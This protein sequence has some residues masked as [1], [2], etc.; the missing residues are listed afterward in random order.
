MIMNSRLLWFCLL[1]FPLACTKKDDSKNETIQ[2]TP[3]E[4]TAFID[5]S[6]EA[7]SSEPENNPSQEDSSNSQ[8]ESGSDNEVNQDNTGDDEQNSEDGSNN[9]AV[10]RKIKVITDKELVSAYELLEGETQMTA[11]CKDNAQKTNLVIQ[12]FCVEGFR[13]T[14]LAELQ[15]ALNLDPSKVTSRGNNGANGNPGFAITAHSSS[16]VGSFVSAINPRVIIFNSQA[17]GQSFLTKNF[18]AMGFVRGEQFVE[19]MVANDFGESPPDLF[20]VSFKQACNSKAEGCSPG[21]LLTPAIESNW[22]EVA[23]YQD[24]DLKNTMMDCRQCHQPEGLNTKV[25]GRMQELRN[26]WLHW[27]RDNRPN[28]TTL[29]DD[30]YAAHGREETYGGIPGPVIASSD[31]DNLTELMIENGFVSLQLEELEFPSQAILDEVTL[32]DSAQPGD[33]TTP[34]KSS[35]WE[36]LFSLAAGKVSSD[37]RNIIPIPYHDVK[38]TEPALLVEFTQQYQNFLSGNLPLDQFKDHRRVLRTDHKERADMGFAV[39][40]GTAP[41]DILIQACFQCHN[42]KLDDSISRAKFSLGTPG[43]GLNATIG[44]PFQLDLAQMGDR[45]SFE[46]SKA[47]LRLRMGHSTDGLKEAKIQFVDDNGNPVTLEKGQHV[48]TMPPRRFKS[49]TDEQI[50]RVIEYLESEKA[51]LS[52]E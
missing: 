33:N 19:L 35:T 21:D 11:L 49:L 36:N 22:T 38:V 16:L 37:G 46:I 12:K 14:S 31:P 15:V 52:Q 10:F 18:I 26:P 30:Y 17:P 27:M 34:G 13:P 8:V 29:I 41:E 48:L 3:L 44:A 23:V 32:E 4:M 6:E 40:Q 7:A 39:R 1:W 9:T 42:G 25:F 50:H 43:E 5:C 20:L 28:G 2:C 45:A 24:D 51:R 47:I